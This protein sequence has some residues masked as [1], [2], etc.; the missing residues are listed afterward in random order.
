MTA[1]SIVGGEHFLREVLTAV[2]HVRD[3]PEN[4][5]SRLAV[6]ASSW[7]AIF[8]HQRPIHHVGKHL[9]DRIIGRKLSGGLKSTMVNWPQDS[10]STMCSIT[11]ASI[12]RR[13]ATAACSA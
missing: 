3:L 11:I 2:V 4:G 13:I 9:H 6:A 10:I 12:S 8:R 7:R 5:F 1:N